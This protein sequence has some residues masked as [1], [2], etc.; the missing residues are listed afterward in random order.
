MKDFA[1]KCFKFLRLLTSDFPLMYHVTCV[2]F[3]FLGVTE[4]FFY[5]SFHLSYFI[6]S[7]QT[8]FNVLRS[9]W[10]PKY[11]IFMTLILFLLTE[12]LFVII[13]FQMYRDYFPGNNCENLLRC[14]LVTLDQTFKASG[15]VGGFLDPAYLSNESGSQDPNKIDYGR[16]F[17]DFFFN[18]VLIILIIQMISGIIIDKF[19][20]LR[21]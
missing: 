2:I 3:A 8:L 16:L 1:K 19:G 10:E 15:G 11:K 5:F 13:S 12:Y 18:F 20:A 6:I 4:H 17:Y 9:I 14:Y 21:E 7:S